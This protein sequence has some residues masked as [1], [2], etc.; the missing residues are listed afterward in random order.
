[1]NHTARQRS[2]APASRIT[3]RRTRGRLHRESRRATPATIK[4]TAT[5]PSTFVMTAPE[6]AAAPRNLEASGSVGVSA[7]RAATAVVSKKRRGASALPPEAEWTMEIA[8]AT[9]QKAA[10][11]TESAAGTRQ[12]R[13]TRTSGIA[14]IIQIAEAAGATCQGNSPATSVLHARTI[15]TRGG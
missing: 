1:M 9:V 11:A 13:N 7:R 3:P 12:R 14:A 10:T 6:R 8:R 4:A 2:G 5:Q 15:G